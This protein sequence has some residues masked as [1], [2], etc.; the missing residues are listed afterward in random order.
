MT[1]GGDSFKL[2]P[3]GVPFYGINLT[4]YFAKDFNVE[5]AVEYAK[6][7]IDTKDNAGKMAGVKQDQGDATQVPILINVRY[8]PT[9][10]N[11]MPYVGLGLG[12]YFNSFSNKNKNNISL[13]DNFGYLVNCGTDYKLNENNLIG[14]DLR[15]VWDSTKDKNSTDQKSFDMNAFQ[16]SLGYK[17]MF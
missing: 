13:E 2:E 8:Q 11:F 6:P 7:E 5:G 4:Y 14:L 15:Y 10:D 3:S 12:Y 9:V 17:Y 16:V 1:S